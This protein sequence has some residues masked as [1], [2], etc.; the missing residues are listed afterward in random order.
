MLSKLA[1]EDRLRLMKFACAFAWADL[2]I[3]PQEQLFISKLIGELELGPDEI[4]QVQAWLAVPPPTDELDP[5]DIP[6]AHRKLFL[7]VLQQLAN[8]DGRVYRREME[9]FALLE[10]LLSD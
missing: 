3:Q 1:S 7:G 9:S 6:A 4:E 2:N 8:V 5:T 10:D